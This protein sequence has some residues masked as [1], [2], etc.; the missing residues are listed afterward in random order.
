MAPVE[1]SFPANE[2]NKPILFNGTL[3]TGIRLLVILNAVHPQELDLTSLIWLDY[4]IVHTEDIDGPPSLHP[5]I[6][7]RNGE[8]L[9][10]RKL[11]QSSI[12][13]LQ[14]LHFIDITANNSGIT[15]KASE[16][17]PSLLLLL[18]SKYTKDLMLRADWLAKNICS[19]GTEEIEKII[20]NKIGRWCI[21]F[22]NEN[23]PQK[24]QKP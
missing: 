21:E 7:Q 23:E 20:I 14:N 1:K 24:S 19:Q 5:N 10:R 6:P 2:I 16:E 8:L 18:E 3:E 13:L 15:Y 11:I 4:L 12:E 22:H 9:V 17:A